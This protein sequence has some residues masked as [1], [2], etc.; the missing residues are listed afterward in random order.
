[1]NTY[2]VGGAVRDKLLKLAIKDK[3]WVV[4]GST[5]EDMRQQGFTPVGKDF[6]VFLHPETHEEYALARTERKTAA[7]YHGFQFHADNKVTLEEDVKRR[8]LT[9]N[10]LAEDKDGNVLDYVNGQ[11]DLDAR[12]LR[13]VSP[14]FAE[15]PVRILRIARFAARFAPLEF[16]IA[17]ETITNNNMTRAVKDITTLNITLKPFISF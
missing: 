13:H 9:I 8:D 5:P 17:D 11:A 2:L 3:D 6:P 16:Q 12:I 15:D 4:T 1:M 10:A 14:A 7:G